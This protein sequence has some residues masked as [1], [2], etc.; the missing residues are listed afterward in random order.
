MTLNTTN[1]TVAKIWPWWWLITPRLIRVGKRASV[2][3]G[4]WMP[5]KGTGAGSGAMNGISRGWEIILIKLLLLQMGF[6]GKE[7][8]KESFDSNEDVKPSS[9]DEEEL[10]ESIDFIE[11]EKP[12]GL[13]V[14]R[15]KTKK[16]GS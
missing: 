7:E 2:V 3:D 11:D 8:L 5:P 1:L 6:K 16:R 12:S 9:S 13:D 14:T 4:R 15:A 10:E